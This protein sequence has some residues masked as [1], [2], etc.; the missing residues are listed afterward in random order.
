MRELKDLKPTQEGESDLYEAMKKLLFLESKFKKL[1]KLSP[2]YKLIFF[3]SQHFFLYNIFS[4]SK[5]SILSLDNPIV[6]E[7][8]LCIFFVILLSE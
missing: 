4:L 1:L 2:L 7:I 6:L 8:V 3:I 5:N